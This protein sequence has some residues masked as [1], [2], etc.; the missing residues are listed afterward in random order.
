MLYA[1]RKYTSKAN[2]GKVESQL[3]HFLIATVFI[4][5]N[6]LFSFFFSFKF[7]ILFLGLTWLFGFLI[8]IPSPK[9]FL[10]LS[11]VFAVLFCFLN[12]FQ[13]VFIFL[14]SLSIKLREYKRPKKNTKSKYYVTTSTTQASTYSSYDSENYSTELRDV[15]KLF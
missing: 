12:A 10:Y 1:I 8:F 2:D 13:G 3:C 9:D 5:G 14:V 11:F 4:C 6:F 7:E 15:K